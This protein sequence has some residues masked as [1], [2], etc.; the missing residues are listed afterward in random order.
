MAPPPLVQSGVAASESL[1]AAADFALHALIY[2][3]F[4]ERT[5]SLA[6]RLEGLVARL[7]PEAAGSDDGVAQAADAFREAALIDLDALQGRSAKQIKPIQAPRVVKYAGNLAKPQSFFAK[8]VDNSRATPFRPLLVAKPHAL[9]P[10]SAA[11]LTLDANPYAAEILAARPPDWYYSRDAQFTSSTKGD[12][13]DD[14]GAHTWVATPLALDEM[15]AHLADGSHKAIAVDL[16]HHAHRSFLGLTCVLQISTAQR[17]FV[18]DALALR[19]ALSRLLP[20]F[21]DP[22]VVKVLHGANSDVDWLQRDLGLYVVQMFDTGL[23]ARAL[24]YASASFAFALQKHAGV[25]ANKQYQLADWRVRPLSEDMLA[26]A[27]EDTRHLLFIFDRM[28][29]A[30]IDRGADVLTGVVEQSKRLAAKA[31]V[32]PMFDPRA[33]LS[34]A[35]ASALREDDGQL[36]VLAALDDWR[37]ATARELDESVGFVLSDAGAMRLAKRLPTT[38]DALLACLDDAAVVARSAASELLRLVA[39]AAA[40]T[41]SVNAS[42]LP[43]RAEEATA[44]A[45]AA[46]FHVDLEADASLAVNA[47]AVA[48]DAMAGAVL[49]W[50]GVE[51]A[52]AGASA[53]ATAAPVERAFDAVQ[54]ARAPAP[55]ELELGSAFLE[56]QRAFA[57]QP[58][59]VVAAAAAAVVGGL[60][61]E[62][63]AGEAAA[64]EQEETKGGQRAAAVS[65]LV[66]SVAVA[67]RAHGQGEDEE[68][69]MPQDALDAIAARPTASPAAKRARPANPYLRDNLIRPSRQ[70]PASRSFA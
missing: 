8:P 27:R 62:T 70:G 45:M 26:Y 29:L 49:R 6:T 15:V 28:R 4:A 10:W 23:A 17:N 42:P 47:R 18:V 7:A 11:D 63:A 65:A 60:P 39:A 12:D 67:V 19:D 9:S 56:A 59:P 32:K 68:D 3:G 33:F 1:P 48:Y 25:K 31:Y 66:R 55:V 52:L 64:E 50:A 13:D 54:E 22:R 46:A 53:A 14:D 35:G 16:E 51:A 37:D 2:P 58:V 20:V 44:P 38:P 61:D 40:S 43:E 21:A 36:A 30:L 5:A 57:S 34:I 41:V 24:G 69:A